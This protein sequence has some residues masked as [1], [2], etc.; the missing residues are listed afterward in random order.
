MPYFLVGVSRLCIVYVY[1]DDVLFL[2]FGEWK[3]DELAKF[4]I[5]NSLQYNVN[6]AEGLV[7]PTYVFL[8][9][10]PGVIC[11]I[12]NHVTFDGVL[13]DVSQKCKEVFPVVDGLA[14]ETLL[15]EVTYAVVLMVVVIDV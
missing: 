11:C 4:F 2:I 9:A 14:L 3:C 1:V 8:P 7:R 6:A 10:A 13:M 12:G 5:S 15:E